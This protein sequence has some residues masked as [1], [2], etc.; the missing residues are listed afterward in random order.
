MP[1]TVFGLG[2]V[3]TAT[4]TCLAANGHHVVGADI[5]CDKVVTI[6][7]GH[8][9]LVVQAAPPVMLDLNGRLAPRLEAVPGDAGVGW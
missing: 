5:D 9:P 2:Y 7:A 8:S 3:E 6:N 4:A 1:I